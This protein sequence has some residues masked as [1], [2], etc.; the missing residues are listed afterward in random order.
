MRS[1]RL[2]VREARTDGELT[3]GPGRIAAAAEAPASG[4][5]EAAARTRAGRAE[6][7]EPASMGVGQRDAVALLEA[8]ELLRGP[9]RRELESVMRGA[10]HAPL[11]RVRRE[12]VEPPADADEV[13]GWEI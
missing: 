4:H 11:V 6:L 10:E 2:D 7:E 9:R 1:R 13:H 8:C 12:R 3:R 5:E